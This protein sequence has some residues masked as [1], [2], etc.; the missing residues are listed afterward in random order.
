M[1]EIING[2]KPAVAVYFDTDKQT[3]RVDVGP[4]IKN[5]VLAVFLL[6]ESRKYLEAQIQLENARAMQQQMMQE[7]IAQAEAA[8]LGGRLI[9]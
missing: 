5:P 1:S 2:A 4:T 8:R 3:I 6:E 7:Q 9:R